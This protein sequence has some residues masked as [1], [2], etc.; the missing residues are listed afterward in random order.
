MVSAALEHGK[1]LPAVTIGGKEGDTKCEIG[2]T[3]GKDVFELPAF[4]ARV[5]ALDNHVPTDV[6]SDLYLEARRLLDRASRW[7]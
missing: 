1:L 6:Q 7:L 5:S 4:W 3:F 2:F